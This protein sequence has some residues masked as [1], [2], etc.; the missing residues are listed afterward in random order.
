MQ[1]MAVLSLANYNLSINFLV[2]HYPLQGSKS[3]V[4]GSTSLH[5]KCGSAGL[6]LSSISSWFNILIIFCR[7]LCAV[8]ST[9]RDYRGLGY[10]SGIRNPGKGAVGLGHLLRGCVV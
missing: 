5:L 3:A 6:Y 2:L 10:P 8:L 1:C 9:W 4:Q 7:G